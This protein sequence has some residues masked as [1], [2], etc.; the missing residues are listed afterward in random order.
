[1]VS[2]GCGRYRLGGGSMAPFSV[3]TKGIDDTMMIKLN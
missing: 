3:G 1:M 2:R